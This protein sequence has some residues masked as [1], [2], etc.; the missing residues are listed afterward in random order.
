MPDETKP[1]LQPAP[2]LS[3]PAAEGWRANVRTMARVI[4][5]GARRQSA[6]PAPRTRFNPLRLAD[7]RS[8][9]FA[10]M[11]DWMWAPLMLL[12][13][14]SVTITFLVAQTIAN[15]PFDRHLSESVSVLAA[16]VKESGGRVSLELAVPASEVL[17]TGATGRT[18]F[19]VLGTRG[20]LIDGDLE[21]PLPPEDEQPASGAVK[22]RYERIRGEEIRI[23]YTWVAFAGENSD[24]EPALVQIGE[25]LDSR[26]ELAN[27]IVRGVIVPQFVILPIAVM[28]VWFGLTRGL[29]PLTSLQATIRRR[30]PDDLSPIDPR[31]APEELEP[32]VS[33]FNELLQRLSQNLTAQRRFIA[34]AAH[35]M[36][37]PLAGLRTQAELALRETDPQELK[38]SL[39]Q[40]AGASERA[41]H[42]I[43]Q[44]LSLARAEH[45]ATDLAAF[46]MVDL[47]ALARD[48]VRDWVPV[49]L[50]RGID[51]GVELPD[52]RADVIGMPVQLR[53]LLKN[54]VDNALRY[55]PALATPAS[56]VT[57]RVRRAARAVTLDVEDTGPGIA[58][59]ERHLVFERFYRVLGTNVDGSGLGLAIV[60]EIVSQHDALLRIGVNPRADD[61]ERPG[62]LISIEFS[63]I[64]DAPPTLRIDE[65]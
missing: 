31:G 44:L 32:L 20:E 63:H 12:W 6:A 59:A 39:R 34:D 26:S 24:L 7:E 37:T 23:A 47:V 52:T 3:A 9:L 13:P 10:E 33:S 40:M 5:P 41:A 15:A 49:A 35:Q 1:S 11:L 27:E 64:A 45:Q 19:M 29:A 50:A 43:N 2:D 28:L 42:L 14:L 22:L 53:E 62:T 61:P 38:R 58:S 56:R 17:R 30:R 25:T 54:L 4:T 18:W 57:V 51:F 46:E 21:L 36:K 8:S 65:P 48:V 55:T 60:R 16:H